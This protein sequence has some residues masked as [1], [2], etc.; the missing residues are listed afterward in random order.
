MFFFKRD[1]NHG[2]PGSIRKWESFEAKN[3]N[4]L[5]IDSESPKND[6]EIFKNWEAKYQFWLRDLPNKYFNECKLKNFDNF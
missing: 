6:K 2:Y 4:I 3:P 1:V 5:N